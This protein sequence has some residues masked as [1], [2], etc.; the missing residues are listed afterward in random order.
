MKALLAKWEKLCARSRALRFVDGNLRGIGQ[1]MFQDNPLTGLFFLAAICW[2]SYAAGVPH[3]A[4]AGVLAIV[5]ATLTA[6]WLHADD[7][8][9]A[10]GLYGYNSILVGLA[11]ATFLDPGPLLWVYVV[12]GAVA[13]VAVTIGTVTVVKPWGWSALTYPFVITSWLL[14]LAT[15]GFAGLTGTALPSAEAVA[16]YEPYEASPL[17][18]ADFVQGVYQSI[19]QVFLKASGV[20]ALLLLAGLAVNSLAAAAF[21]LG[22][23]I[24]AVATAHLFGAES[25]LITGGLLGFSPVLTAIALGTV[26][27]QPSLRVV[28]YTAVAT[29]FTVIAQSALNAALSPFAIPAL[30][31]PFILVTWLFTLPSRYLDDTATASPDAP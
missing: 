1:V 8:K 4:V 29:I 14:L 6:N 20:A 17:D 10:A 19:S 9:L 25:T 18:L 12:L 7:A 11:V 26:F 27:Y 5:V 16:P 30:T 15:Y 31:A 3:V 23:A 22:G 13:S 28:A 24:L 2:G 21:A